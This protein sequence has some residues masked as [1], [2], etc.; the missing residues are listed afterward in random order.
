MALRAA[1]AQ[2]LRRIGLV[3]RIE[4]ADQLRAGWYYGV[5]AATV[6]VVLLIG[7]IA[8]GS[9]ALVSNG[10]GPGE[11]VPVLATLSAEGYDVELVASPEAARRR[12]LRDEASFAARIGPDAT[13]DLF[14]FDPKARDRVGALVEERV[15]SLS[16]GACERFARRNGAVPPDL[17][18]KA[19]GL[20]GAA[21]PRD[22]LVLSR[23]VGAV[24]G[25]AMFF[26]MATQ[27]LGR[28]AIRRVL[29]TYT[30]AEFL[31]GRFFSGAI[32]GSLIAAAMIAALL[33]L[34]L[35]LESPA[36]L[37]LGAETAVLSAV[38][39]G[40]FA[41]LAPRAIANRA[42]DDLFGAFVISV[43]GMLYLFAFAGVYFPLCGV[44]PGIRAVVEWLPP[45]PSFEIMTLSG[46]G[47]LGPDAPPV[48]DALVR[49]AASLVALVAVDAWL[50]RRSTA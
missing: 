29:R 17:P 2:K 27:I 32:L 35:R 8:E 34:G 22:M 48:H 47:G 6:G 4:L 9:L 42:P 44:S 45:A 24:F 16:T 37:A 41:A 7:A 10:A 12:V 3:A 38:A 1:T 15:L 20:L 21:G 50:I 46:L 39:F 43:F 28:D 49:F 33:S 23:A 25:V 31:V 13:L 26:T 40:F 5:L 14:C 11:P 36:G 30:L 18:V 19:D